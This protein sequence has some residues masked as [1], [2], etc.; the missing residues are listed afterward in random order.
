MATNE[1]KTYR[2]PKIL[3][4][5]SF[6]G[7]S[8]DNFNCDESL[9]TDSKIAGNGQI[10]RI[11]FPGNWVTADITFRVYEDD[12]FSGYYELRKADGT[13]NIAILNCVANTTVPLPVIDFDSITQFTIESSQAQNATVQIVLQSIYQ[14]ST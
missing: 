12:T 5:L 13:G 9:N 7:T 11:I 2:S 1:Q 10:R 4:P 14:V 8:S 3:K 6:S